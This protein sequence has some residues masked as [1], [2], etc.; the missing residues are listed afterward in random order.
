MLLL[1]CMLGVS[2]IELARVRQHADFAA[3]H[4]R[5]KDDVHGTRKGVSVKISRLAVEESLHPPEYVPAESARSIGCGAA[6]VIR[7]A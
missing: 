5:M 7:D 3:L 4:R 1:R 6:C 2:K